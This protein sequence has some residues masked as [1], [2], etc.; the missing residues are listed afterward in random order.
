MSE[1]KKS[2]NFF[3]DM[4]ARR[5]TSIAVVNRRLFD[6]KLMQAS[7]RKIAPAPTAAKPRTLHS[8]GPMAASPYRLGRNQALRYSS[9]ASADVAEMFR[10]R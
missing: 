3:K 5:G 9:K 1:S 2:L 10:N 8:P 7:D 4:L 6:V